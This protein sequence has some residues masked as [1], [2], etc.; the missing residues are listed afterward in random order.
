MLMAKSDLYEANSI[1]A[2]YFKDS[3]RKLIDLVMQ[4]SIYL[5]KNIPKDY[6]FSVSIKQP[7]VQL[8]PLEIEQVR[9]AQLANGHKNEVD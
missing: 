3:I 5:G 6:K 7:K 2:I 9:S 8:S 1:D 4:A